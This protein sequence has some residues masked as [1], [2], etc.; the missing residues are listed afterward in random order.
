[1]A[2]PALRS[3]GDDD[4]RPRRPAH[5]H[6]ASVVITVISAVWIE[7]I[8][9]SREEADVLFASEIRPR[10]EGDDAGVRGDVAGDDIKPERPIRAGVVGCETLGRAGLEIATEDVHRLIAVAPDE[11]VRA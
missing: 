9:V 2:D 6:R 7:H 3:L 5:P 8:Y 1:M 11:V 10:Q 4:F